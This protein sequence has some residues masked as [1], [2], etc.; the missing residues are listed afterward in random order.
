MVAEPWAH[1]ATVS[2]RFVVYLLIANCNGYCLSVSIIVLLFYF[3]NT[4]SYFIDEIF[5]NQ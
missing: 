1:V 5:F 3:V 4:V 2:L